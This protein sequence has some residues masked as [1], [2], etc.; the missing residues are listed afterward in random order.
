[1]SW[2]SSDYASPDSAVPNRIDGVTGL[3]DYA[4]L[5][6]GARE[7]PDA[8]RPPLLFSSFLSVEQ[9]RTTGKRCI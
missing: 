2:A 3:P 1:M 4:V 5:P 6:A 8:Y 7:R 9:Q